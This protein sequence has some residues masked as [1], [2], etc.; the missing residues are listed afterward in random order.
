MGN[1]DC[2]SMRKSVKSMKERSDEVQTILNEMIDNED[3]DEKDFFKIA[4]CQLVNPRQKLVELLKER[5]I[6]I[7]Q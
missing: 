4:L 5:A 2:M 7:G 6:I 3:L 1:M